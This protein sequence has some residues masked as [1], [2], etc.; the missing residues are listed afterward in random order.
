MVWDPRGLCKVLEL[1][2]IDIDQYCVPFCTFVNE[3]TRA[4]ISK[5]V[6]NFQTLRSARAYSH[7]SG[8][9]LKSPSFGGS[10]TTLS[11]TVTHISGR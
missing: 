10:R 4:A 1:W 9:D 5:Q 8:I 7:W 6:V 3:E 11:P 2:L